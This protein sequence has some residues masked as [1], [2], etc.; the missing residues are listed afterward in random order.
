MGEGGGAT[1][2]RRDLHAPGVW[3]SGVWDPLE[4][5]SQVENEG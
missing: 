1:A 2:D 3:G 4:V 5:D